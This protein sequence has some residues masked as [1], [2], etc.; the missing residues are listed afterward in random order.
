MDRNT[1]RIVCDSSRNK[2][3][4]FFRNKPKEWKELPSDSPLL[5]SKYKNTLFSDK[6]KDILIKIDEIYNI[7]NNG[8][9]VFFEGTTEEYKILLKT[10]EDFLPG[11]N[12]HCKA[13]ST[14]I[15]IIGKK[16][17][18]KSLLVEGIEKLNGISY[19]KIDS[20]GYVR[21][22]NSSNSINFYEIAGMDLGNE[23]IE[24][25]YDTLKKI[26]EEKGLSSIIYC[27][28]ATTGKVESTEKEF[29]LRIERD[30]SE[31]KVIIALT[32]CYMDDIQRIINRIKNSIGEIVIFPVLS[33]E[34]KTRLK[35]KHEE[36]VVIDGFG[37]EDISRFIFGEI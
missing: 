27:I 25:A 17:V 8:V 16:S 34:Y 5:R 10:V 19:Q 35:D 21:Y 15:A 24:K 26:S 28:S 7:K 20:Y 3:S 6:A 14:K 13:G 30:L 18:G 32:M 11:R 36:K 37:L 12:I 29:I 1:V 31:T 4:Y 22:S 2:I 9:D 23:N 33:K